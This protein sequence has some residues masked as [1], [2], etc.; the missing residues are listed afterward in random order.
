MTSNQMLAKLASDLPTAI[1]NKQTHNGVD[2]WS[3]KI[4][5][6]EGSDPIPVGSMGSVLV[7]IRGGN[8][9]TAT[10]E[11]VSDKVLHTQYKLGESNHFQR[12]KLLAHCRKGSG[13]TNH[14]AEMRLEAKDNIPA[15]FYR[16]NS[17]HQA[18][19]D[20]LHKNGERT[21]KQLA[22]ALD[23]RTQAIIKM[24][25][26]ET[27]SPVWIYGG[28]KAAAPKADNRPKTESPD[29]DKDAK[30]GTVS[31]KVQSKYFK[32]IL[33]LARCGMNVMMVGP[34]GCGKTY[35]SREVANALGREFGMVSC[36]EGMSESHLIGWLLPIGEQNAMQYVPS[37]F[38]EA[39]ENGG[40]YLIDEIDAADPN[41][42]VYT[43]AAL[44]GEYFD[45][46]QR[47]KNRR[48][49]RH[50][51]FVCLAA[52]NTLGN[53]ANERYVGRNELDAATLDRFRSA[54]VEMDYDTALE[55]NL[56]RAAVLEWG[57]Q[58][59]KAIVEMDLPHEMS[60]RLM[61]DFSKQ[62]SAGILFEDMKGSYFA[63]WTK[64]EMK[65]L[66]PKLTPKTG[67][68]DAS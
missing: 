7:S 63:D 17:S 68:G 46:V 9:S 26:D 23:I 19:M 24:L 20:F 40:V 8:F 51:N 56:C 1:Y 2:E 64:D 5:R 29:A 57:W 33:D 52:A 35:I 41:T 62:L 28:R 10:V 45:V 38:V 37:G 16:A 15:S 11:I 22:V 49:K 58:V 21:V 36:S 50:P 47:F 61:I 44:A 43:N 13:R 55:R 59:R 53:G 18:A 42:L 3:V 12:A 65:R 6:P 4:E 34:T 32:R 31:A 30:D 67:M 48:I 54:I 14:F 60:T 66:D 25:D 39:Y 27:V